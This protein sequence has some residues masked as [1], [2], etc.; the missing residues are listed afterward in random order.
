MKRLDDF[1]LQLGQKEHVPIVLGGMGVDIS[2][3]KLAQTIALQGG[4]GHISDALLPCLTDQKFGTRFVKNKLQKYREHIKSP[5]KSAV[6]FDLGELAEATKMYITSVMEGKKG[7]GSIFINC[8]EKL[9]MNSPLETLK[10]RLESAMDG[11]IDGIT[12]SAG[13]NLRSF[14]LIQNHR[15]FKDVK[16]GIVVSS[17]RALKLF[18]KKNAKIR[19]PDYVVVEGPLAGGHLGFGAL[20]WRKYDLFTIVKEILNFLAKEDLKI[21]IIPAGGIFSGSEGVRFMEMGCSAI[22]VATRF[23]I[24]EECGLPHRVKQK[25]VNATEEDVV[26]NTISP[27][28][29]PMRM[30]KQS[31]AIGAGN[32]PNCEAYGYIL[33]GSG[34]CSYLDVYNK[35]IAA[36]PS[37]ANK[38]SIDEKTCI[39]TQMRSFKVWTCG[40]NVSRLRKTAH[41]LE[42]GTWQLPSAEHIFQDY[43]F[44]TDYEVH[45]PPP[46]PH[47]ISKT[48]L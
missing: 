1:R 30:L 2:T 7:M 44:S 47:V 19:L 6:K 38:L 21:P 18:L 25:Y 41:Q 20:D 28:G 15:R 23:T 9:N 43:Q 10:V 36:N 46:R 42:D 29:Y 37:G 8:M 34:R 14:S 31:P 26:V 27:T 13:L 11:G 22:Q 48:E 32:R 39:C 33:D 24:A 45:P 40:H 17:L 12:L 4:I 5:D 35:A 16:L 3:P